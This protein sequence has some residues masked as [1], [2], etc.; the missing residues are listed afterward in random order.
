MSGYNQE[1]KRGEIFFISR[2][3]NYPEYGSEQYA[4]RPAIVVSNQN[5]NATSSTV[6]IVYLTTKEKN[7]S[8]LHVKI[9]STIK[10]SVAICEQIT[11]ISKERIGD[12]YG[13]CTDEE[14][15][16][17]DIAI[18]K[19][20]GLQLSS[21]PDKGIPKEEAAQLIEARKKAEVERDTYKN[22]YDILLGKL[23]K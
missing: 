13:T 21:D 15:Q 19:S 22:M 11:S 14:L 2:S 23:L 3:D 10:P 20:L 12:Y 4:G 16:K 7:D 5:L 1:I 18:A 9:R 6:E 17:I 8:L